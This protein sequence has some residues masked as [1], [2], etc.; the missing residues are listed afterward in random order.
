MLQ[1][2]RT[3]EICVND[4]MNLPSVVYLDVVYMNMIPPSTILLSLYLYVVLLFNVF[5]FS[6]CVC[7]V[8]CYK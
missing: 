1:V 8:V 2:N 7:G 3:L 6:P 5:V 4:Q